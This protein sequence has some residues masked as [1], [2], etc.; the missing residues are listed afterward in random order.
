MKLKEPK[1]FLLAQHFPEN[2]I[3]ADIKMTLKIPQGEL[4]NTKLKEK[5]K[6]QPFISVFNSKQP[7]NYKKHKNFVK[8]DERDTRE[9]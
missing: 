4:R 2:I 1:T 8:K 9:A 5:K 3:T 6:I 7:K